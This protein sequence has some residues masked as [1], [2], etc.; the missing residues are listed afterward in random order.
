MEIPGLRI[1]SPFTIPSG[2]VTT[3][4]TVIARIARDIPEIG[5]LTTKTISVEPREGY[6]EPI[7][8]EYYPGCFVNAVGLAN[9]GAKNFLQAMQP[10]LPLHENKPLL[11]SIMGTNVEEFLQC[12]LILNPIADAFELNLSCP[13]VKGAGQSIGSDP[14]A[15]RSIIG[16]LKERID[17]PVIPKLS[18]NLGDIPGM[19]RVCKEAGADGLCLINTVGPGT[20]ADVDG[21]PILTNTAGGLSGAG[22]L[23]VGIKAVREAAA[24]VDLPIIAMGGITCA[25]DV[26][27]YKQAG[28]S[29]FG[30]GSALADMTTP[31]IV[32]FF[33]ELGRPLRQ[34]PEQLS[35]PKCIATAS[36]TTYVKTTVTRNEPFGP[37]LF[38]LSLERGPACNPG[39]FFFLRLPGIGEKPFSPAGDLEPTYFV[40]AVGPFTRALQSLKPGDSIFMRGPYGQGFP[41]PASGSRIVLVAGGTGAAPI[42]MALARWK[43]LAVRA[44]F[45]FSAPIESWFQ[46]EIRGSRSVSSSGSLHPDVRV[47]IDSPDHVGEVVRAL[48]EDVVSNPALYTDCRVFVCGPDPM[49]RATVKALENRVPRGKIFP[50]RE[51]IMRCGI[52]ICGSCGTGTGLRSCVDGPVMCAE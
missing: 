15:V 35:P 23:P 38:K 31:Q 34:R 20:A 25:D 29:Y 40:R 39:R 19:A 37:D 51:D 43:E 17:K 49:M 6:R 21:N 52:G 1:R 47:V 18:P 42:L 36:R 16:L 8:Y 28:A 22:I 50:A 30:V 4:P 12:A 32:S 26:L 11:V 5:F 7:L 27:A 24:A 41:E 14:N 13:H 44:F 48:E 33:G 3:V 45:G 2:I 10:L 46:D 9:P